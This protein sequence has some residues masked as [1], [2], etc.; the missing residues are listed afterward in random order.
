[1]NGI[2]KKSLFILLVLTLAWALGTFSAAAWAADDVICKINDVP[3]EGDLQQAVNA[4]P[5]G[6]VITLLEPQNELEYYHHQPDGLYVTGKTLTMDCGP[7]LLIIGDM[8][9]SNSYGV[10][11]GGGAISFIGSAVM[12][13]FGQIGL[14]A[15]AGSSI[16]I[17]CRPYDAE[18]GSNTA[19]YSIVAA[20]GA[21]S[22][23]YLDG[24]VD[25]QILEEGEAA[26]SVAGGANITVTGSVSSNGWGV[27]ASG[28]GQATVTNI[29]EGGA[30]ANG[31]NSLV[32]VKGESK[33]GS[34]GAKAEDGGKVLVDGDASGS[35]F[36]AFADGLGSY[37]DV[38]GSAIGS[39]ATSVGVYTRFSGEVNVTRDAIG[40]IY[41][42]YTDG[43]GCNATV[44]D[45]IATDAQ[46]YA[47]VAL[48]GAH[49]TVNRNAEGQMYGVYADSLGS[50]ITVNGAAFCSGATGIAAIARGEAKITV[51]EDVVSVNYIGAFADTSGSVTVGGN[52]SG[53][54]RGAYATGALS[55]I[56]I[57][58]DAL[59]LG[60]GSVGAQAW[61]GGR[62]SVA[63]Q[64]NGNLNGAEADGAQ[65]AVIVEGNAVASTDTAAIAFGG[66]MVTVAGN[67]NGVKF[68]AYAEDAGSTAIVQGTAA[69]INQSGYCG[70][71][72]NLGAQIEA[73]AVSGGYY[74]AVATNGS[75]ATVESEISG[76]TVYITVGDGSQTVNKDKGDYDTVTTKAGYDTYSSE[77]STVWVKSATEVETASFNGL[78]R[79]Q[80]STYQAT[81]ELFNSAKIR[82]DSTASA[83]DGTYTVNAPPGAG[84][85]LVITKPGYLS[86]TIENLTLTEGVDIKTVDIRQM[87]G[88][89]DGDGVVNA[90]DL[91][92][93][94]SEFNRDPLIYFFADF[95]GNKVVN[96]TDLT[97]LLAGFNKH[98]F[99]DDNLSYTHGI[100]ES[101]VPYSGVQTAI[102]FSPPQPL[103]PAGLSVPASL[104]DK[105]IEQKAEDTGRIM[106]Q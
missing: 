83:D 58:K 94:L 15:D 38:A 1:M 74:G 13:V 63:G 12:Q 88:D 80:T 100:P 5:D 37:V 104:P 4:A 26:V 70:L 55:I 10:L 68:G 97:Y 103:A 32:Q 95:D 2:L 77:T 78:V 20:Q 67:A 9:N 56:N 14:F 60:G 39:G 18:A 36:G 29:K 42:L 99:V 76:C 3:F 79:Y 65:S 34:Y 43:A 31:Q 28:G 59:A 66:G 61:D 71:K 89:V 53:D 35:A 101:N 73:G 19:I 105:S 62:V 48:N 16:N 92:Y 46:G 87:A 72:S 64:A 21:G 85:T 75:A 50:S 93:L 51:E 96:A 27:I 82:I 47:A 45:A 106:Q 7:Y 25:V 52:S 41:G 98:D 54:Q 102:N 57:A 90:T 24:E 69:A 8:D 84:Y 11:A 86:Y 91:T 33:G 44:R 40:S 17:N 49:L 30:L 81:V 23:I 6:A 22:S